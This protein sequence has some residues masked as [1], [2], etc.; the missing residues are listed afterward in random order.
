MSAPEP[1]NLCDPMLDPYNREQQLKLKVQELEDQ[2]MQLQHAR[3]DLLVA[4]NKMSKR[5]SELNEEDSM[6][7]EW[8]S[9][10]RLYGGAA[11]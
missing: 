2:I 8:E 11:W 4:G 3:D 1:M 10:R 6:L 5:I 9:V 7:E